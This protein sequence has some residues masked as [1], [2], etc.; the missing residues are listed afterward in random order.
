MTDAAFWD[1]ASSHLPSLTGAVST[2]YYFECER[3]QIETFFSS[4]SGRRV[5]KT[6]LWDEAKNTEILRWMA[7]REAHPVGIDIS[8]GIARQARGVLEGQDRKS[9]RLNSSHIQKSRMPSSA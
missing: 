3:W 2:A 8:L 7:G 1:N 9:T 6:D 5:L 4:L